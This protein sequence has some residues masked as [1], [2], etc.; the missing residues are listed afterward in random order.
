LASKSDILIK[1]GVVVTGEGASR[2]D[3][4][5]NDGKITEIS[6]DLSDRQTSRTLDATGKYVMPGIVDAHAHP[7]YGDKMDD[8]S[9]CAAFGGVTTII[10]FIGNVSAWGYTGYTPEV[11][12]RFIE[13]SERI[14]YT[15]F[16]VH[17]VFVG[18][19]DVEKA[20]PELID[21]GVISF[22]MFM[23]YSRR[24]MMMPDDKML[25]A[26][27][28]ASYSG[29]LAMVHAENGHCIDFLVDN[30]IATGKTNPEYFL[31]SQPNIIEA[32]AFNRALTYAEVTGCPLYG[33]H[34][35]TKE[36]LP[37]LRMFQ[38][39][40]QMVFGETCP[41]YLALTND[42]VL[43]KGA[44][45]KVAP[46]LREWSDVMAL[47][48]ALSNGLLSTVGSDSTGLTVAQKR[49]GGQSGTLS[50]QKGDK[51][52]EPVSIFDARFG[53]NTLQYMSSVVFT[54][55]V[56]K[57]RISL[58]RFV[59]VMCENPAKIFGMYPQ[60][61]ALKPGSDADLVVWD[62][63]LSGTASIE[64]MKGNADFCTFENFQLQGMPILTMQRGNV[65]VEDGKLVAQ[66]GHARYVPG[67]PSRAAYAP[68]AHRVE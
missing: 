64:N 65:I 39:R 44:L 63:E 19:D 24:G 2:A 32:E 36:S 28:V 46:P 42:E 61:G 54:E 26:M 9:I 30:F 67:D 35:S 48:A 45:G 55:G 10:A 37:I 53:L 3:I 68:G 34:L 33:V 18:E 49:T 25:R 20:I 60:K 58:A 6:S 12:K 56:Q 14:S 1:G 22:K 43:T 17:G 23:A 31:R 16:S 13:D 15:D 11:A 50:L 40:G 38:E 47:W 59:Q 41:H 27:Q 21:L 66:Q 4:L 51:M 5:V 8:Y 7:V 62:S 52:E 57:G 29:G